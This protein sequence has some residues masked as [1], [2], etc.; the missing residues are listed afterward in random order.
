[1]A[2]RIIL[3]SGPISAG[4]TTL[5]NGLAARYGIHPIKTGDLLRERFSRLKATRGALQRA[6][7]QLDTETNHE[8]VAQDVLRIVSSLEDDVAIAVDSVRTAAQVAAFREAFGAKVKHMHLTAPLQ[9]LEHRYGSRTGALREFAQYTQARR[10]PTERNV[11][12]LASIADIAVNTERSS[13]DDVLVRAAAQLGYY[14]R[15]YARLVDVLVGGQWGSEGKGHIASYLAPEYQYLVRVG[16][17]NAGHKVFEKQ[18]PFTFHQLPSGS[19]NSGAGLLIAPGAVITVN[20]LRE[21]INRCELEVG[22]LWIDPKAMVIDPKDAEFEAATLK[23][24]IAS[25]AQGVGA[26][27]AR[28]LMR[29]ALAPGLTRARSL[30]KVTL[31]GDVPDLRPWIRDTREILDD[32]FHERSLV[33][34]E[35]TQGTG[36]SVYHGQYP[37]VTSRDTSVAGCLSE[38]GIAASRLRKAIMVVRTYP[39][40]VQNPDEAGNESGPMGREIEWKDVADRSGVP[41]TELEQHEKTS[42]TKRR[43]RV[44]EFNWWLLRRSASI[45]GPT[46]IALSFADYLSVDNRDARRFEQLTQDT[47]NFVEEIERVTACLVMTVDDKYAA[48]R[49]LNRDLMRLGKAEQLRNGTCSLFLSLCVDGPVVEDVDDH[50][51]EADLEPGVVWKPGRLVVVEA[52]V[53]ERSFDFRELFFPTPRV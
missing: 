4:K 52:S 30:K 41:L 44:A 45:N 46:D 51:F 5:A 8:W 9:V 32:A 13:G 47:I 27:S 16:G 38:A 1:M 19:R 53:P 3:L 20:D 10:D 48:F 15:S 12:A 28:R 14:G 37:H 2:S 17:P 24:W 7:E 49:W 31:A 40:R 21:E 35:G 34:V 36:L 50:A 33:F 26:A 11:E 22:R 29:G 42:T 43:R 18:G 6:G 23:K 25:T 39:I